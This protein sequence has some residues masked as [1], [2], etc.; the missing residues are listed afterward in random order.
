[1]N[2]KN[3]GKNI[4]SLIENEFFIYLSDN[5]FDI[6]NEFSFQH[7]L[8]IFLRI[9]LPNYKIEFERN[10]SH[11]NEKNKGDKAWVKREIDVVII[12]QNDEHEKYAIELKYPTNGQAP[13]QMFSFIKDIKFLEQLKRKLK[14][15]QTFSFVL[16]DN[17]QFW[18]DDEKLKKE[19]IYS[20][21]RGD[22]NINGI[23]KKPTGI[24][25]NDIIIE[26][27]GR[28]SVEWQKWGKLNNEKENHR[29][30]LLTI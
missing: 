19:G 1:M 2:N 18:S 30:Y 20:Y 12:N 27:S 3:I 23:I 17:K 8:G 28:Y 22:K 29:Y 6:Y 14:F 7:E 4:T 15:T 26:V 24:E 11:F 21:F 5:E 16:V 13:E 25:K 9:K 10:V